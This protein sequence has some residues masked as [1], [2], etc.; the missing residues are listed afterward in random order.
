[1]EVALEGIPCRISFALGVCHGNWEMLSARECFGEFYLFPL[2]FQL[3]WFN[4]Y[5]LLSEGHFLIMFCPGFNWDKVDFLLSW[6]S[7]VF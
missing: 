7:A 4:F 5:F 2:P 3:M 1:M 6:C